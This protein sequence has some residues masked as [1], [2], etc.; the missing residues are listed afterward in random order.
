MKSVALRGSLI[1]A[2][3]TVVVLGFGTTIELRA[4]QAPSVSPA[5]VSKGEWDA[6]TRYA[7]DDLVTS[8]GSTWRAKVSNRHHTPGST[9]PDTSAYWE[10]FA[11]GFNP[12]GAWSNVATY[13]PDDLVTS[14]G[15]TYRAKITNLD[16]SPTNTKVWE[17][18]AAKGAMGP[19]GPNT[20]ISDGTQSKPGIAFSGDRNTG[21]YSPGSGKVAL[22]EDGVLFLHNLGS[23]NTA[24]G[25]A[26]ITGNTSGSQNTALGVGALTQNQSGSNNTALGAFALSS[27]TT[28]IFNTAVGPSALFS[29]S[30]GFNNTALGSTA[31]GNNTTAS[32]N[33]AVGTSAMLNNKTGGNNTAIGASALFQNTTGQENTAVGRSALMSNADGQSNTAVGFSALSTNTNGNANTALGQFALTANSGGGNNTAAGFDALSANTTGAGNTAIGSS[34]LESNTSGGTNTAIGTGALGGNTTGIRNTGLGVATLSGNTDGGSNIAV[35]DSAGFTPTHPNNSIFIGNSGLAGDTSTIKI[36]TQ[37]LQATTFIAGIAGANAGDTP[38]YV[39]SS[40][41]QLGVGIS[42]S[43]RRYKNDINT[44][45]DMTKAL[46]KLRP[47]TFRYKNAKS[48]GSHPLQYGL[49]AEEVA[50][51][52]PDLAFYDRDGRPGGVKYHLLP[53][54]LLSGWQAQQKTIAA[55]A[56]KIDA[57][58]EEGHRQKEVNAALET[59]LERLEKLLPAQTQAAALR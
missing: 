51:V 37:G 27:N 43:S 48:D 59:R 16:K 14:N 57:L 53:A 4:Q 45:G 21:I 3:A 26:A 13:E 23:Q 49:I 34:A 42:I 2:V 54:F 35:G 1:A 19:A 31:L 40:T 25:L 24:L 52:I 15:Q 39:D 12:T 32:D 33:T 44:M 17:L 7:A 36:G 58:T 9:H 56:E 46:A 6:N 30:S 29:N 28:G 55:Q 5:L 22:V 11:R 41:G 20:G 8:R 18:F 50:E 47:V 38:V 10:L